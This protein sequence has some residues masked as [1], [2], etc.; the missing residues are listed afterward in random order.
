M[1]V[2]LE[3]QILFIFLVP[4]WIIIRIILFFN[5]K[6]RRVNFSLKNEA[7][8]NIFFIYILCLLSVTLFP[9]IIGFGERNN[10]I[11]VNLIPIIGT[12]KEVSSITSDPNMQNFMIKFWIK[13]IFG[14]I[15]LLLPLGVMMPMLWKQFDCKKKM[16]LFA[17]CLSLSIETLQL[18]SGFIGN[19]GRAFDIDDILLNTIGAFIGFILYDRFVKSRKKLV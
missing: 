11:S 15:L 19:M 14:N 9:L 5:N 8:L 1:G 3:K 10:W 12:A 4:I 17:F 13:N 6:K 18:L 2:Y 16:I 7:G